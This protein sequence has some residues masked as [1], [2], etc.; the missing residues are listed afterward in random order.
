M[1]VV[2]DEEESGDEYSRDRAADL[3][4]TLTIA[5]VTPQPLPDPPVPSPGT[6]YLNRV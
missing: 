4:D 6:A 2:T 1:Q 5:P 3:T